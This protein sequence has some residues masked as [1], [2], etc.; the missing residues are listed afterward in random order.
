M[1]P[2]TTSIIALLRDKDGNVKFD[3]WHNI[4]EIYGAAL[5]TKDKMYIMTKIR[6][7][8]GNVFF[9]DWGNIPAFYKPLLSDLDWQYIARKREEK[10]N[11]CNT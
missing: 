7:E 6:D 9:K 3:D 1:T 10:G 5:T 11:E 8:E 4:S 2:G